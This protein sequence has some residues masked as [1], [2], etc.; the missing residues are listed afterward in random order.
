[1]QRALGRRMPRRNELTSY[2]E[3]IA[4]LLKVIGQQEL[5]TRELGKAYNAVFLDLLPATALTESCWRQFKREDGKITYLVSSAEAVGMMQINL[6]GMASL[7]RLATSAVWRGLYDAERLKW[8]VAYNARAGAQI[9]LHYLEG[10]GLDV[11][12]QTGNPEYLAWA[13][14]AVYNAGPVAAKRFLRKRGELKPGQTD[15]KLLAHYQGFVDGGIADL[16]H[17]VVSQPAE[18]TPA[19]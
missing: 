5:A 17:C 1:M 3:Q 8:E 14:Y 7:R 2:A 10:P 6:Q 12:R 15:R 16:E 9:L 19:L 18:A 13:S 11:V 4:E